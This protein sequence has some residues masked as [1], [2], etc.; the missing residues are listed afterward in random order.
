MTPS[1]ISVNQGTSFNIFCI[2]KPSLAITWSKLNGSFPNG[3]V[4][5]RGTLKVSEAKLKHA[6]TYRCYA[7]NSAGSSE[8]FA[9]VVVYGRNL[10]GMLIKRNIA[11]NKK[12]I[13]HE[14]R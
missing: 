1:K 8:G 10:L 4:S 6:G 9:S 12:C 2:V 13:P 3:I 7:N 5:D 14:L 11:V